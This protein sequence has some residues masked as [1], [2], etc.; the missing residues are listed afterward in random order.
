VKVEYQNTGN[1]FPIVSDGKTIFTGQ[2]ISFHPFLGKRIKLIGWLTTDLTLGTDLGILLNIREHET[3][4]TDGI[5]Y[6]Y[7]YIQNT[8][9]LDIRPRIEIVNYY[10]KLGLTIGYSFGLTNYTKNMDGGNPEAFSRMVR[11]GMAYR[12]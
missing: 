3:G 4:I 6:D 8:Q 2:F 11:F 1:Q 12:F 9:I 5:K 7:N 10:K